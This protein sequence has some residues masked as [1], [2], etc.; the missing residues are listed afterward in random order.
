[1]L[2]SH[3]IDSPSLTFIEPHQQ[4]PVYST[5]FVYLGATAAGRFD[6][7]IRE[8][9]T[10]VKSGEPVGHGLDWNWTF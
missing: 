9:V 6:R 4:L 1:M 5:T 8:L 2:P 3:D 10:A 7:L